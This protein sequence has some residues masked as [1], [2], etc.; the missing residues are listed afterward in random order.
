MPLVVL[1]AMAGMSIGHGFA[2]VAVEGGLALSERTLASCDIGVGFQTLVLEAGNARF[3]PA[4]A[5]YISAV[6]SLMVVILTAHLLVRS[7]PRALGAT[8]S[9]GLVGPKPEQLQPDA[10]ESNYVAYVSN[11]ERWLNSPLQFVAGSVFALLL[12]SYRLSFVG[13]WEIW[14]F[15]PEL[16][17]TTLE[18]CL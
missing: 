18:F 5:M 13:I 6:L 17:P 15:H 14:S 1:P 4:S 2:R 16:D 12:V 7:V 8:W 10:L 9:R 3:S 11:V